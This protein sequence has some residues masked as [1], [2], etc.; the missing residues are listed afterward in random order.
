MNTLTTML[1][2]MTLS[3]DPA[4]VPSGQDAGEVRPA[5][6]V[7]TQPGTIHYSKAAVLQVEQLLDRIRDER[8]GELS[9]ALKLA[10]NEDWAG[11]AE[12]LLRVAEEEA[13]G[14]QLL[15]RYFPH[16]IGYLDEVYSTSSR[17]AATPFELVG[18]VP[19]IQQALVKRVQAQ[20]DKLHENNPERLEQIVLLAEKG[21]WDQAV[22]DLLEASRG[23]RAATLELLQCLP[24]A[25][26]HGAS[27]FDITLS[28]TD[29]DLEVVAEG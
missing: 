4:L 5:K 9:S 7:A 11:A 17:L 20:I 8:G 14:S 10:G 12:Y 18:D 23:E 3:S 16:A 15:V 24:V 19:A 29:P 27:L 1:L 26:R 25:L 22:A 13:R 2:A 28:L 6:T 21:V